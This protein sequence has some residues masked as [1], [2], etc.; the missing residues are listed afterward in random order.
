[1]ERF[2]K[3]AALEEVTPARP[4]RAN[5]GERELVLYKVEGKIFAIENLCPHQQFALFHQGVLEGYTITCPMHNWRFDVRTGKAV[6]SS[7]RIRT[8]EVRIDSNDVF[9]GNPET[10]E[11]FTYF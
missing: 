4:K 1:M 9:V 6:T 3:A 11:R 8:F 5:V 7:G 2:H 10:E